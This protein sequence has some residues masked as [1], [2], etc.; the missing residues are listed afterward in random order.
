MTKQ[1]ALKIL[2]WVV[3]MIALTVIIGAFCAHANADPVDQF[4]SENLNSDSGPAPLTIYWRM[5]NQPTV[6]DVYYRDPWV[7]LRHR[8]WGIFRPVGFHYQ[9]YYYGRTYYPYI[10]NGYVPANQSGYPV[11]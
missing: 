1:T 10:P 4:I 5:N 11:R 8:G 7:P 3:W 2:D 9:R 6:Y